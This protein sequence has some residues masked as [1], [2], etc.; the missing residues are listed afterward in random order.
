MACSGEPCCGPFY[1]SPFPP[2]TYPHALCCM[3]C[4]PPILAPTQPQ[5]VKPLMMPTVCCGDDPPMSDEM[6]EKYRYMNFYNAYNEDWHMST[7]SS[8]PPK[9]TPQDTHPPSSKCEDY[10]RK[11]KQPTKGCP[12]GFLPCDMKL[13]PPCNGHPCGVWSAEIQKCLP[14]PKKSNKYTPGPCTRPCCLHKP[15]PESCCCYDCPCKAHCYDHPVGIKPKNP[16][17]AY[18]PR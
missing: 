9:Q 2:P 13:S 16:W 8:R 17:N 12:T 11:R 7:P 18:P 3:T 4:A 10:R 5:P 14:K 15:V 6:A 1:K